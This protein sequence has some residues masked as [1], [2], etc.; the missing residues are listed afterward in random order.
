MIIQRLIQCLYGDHDRGTAYWAL[1]TDNM[2]AD[3][4]ISMMKTTEIAGMNQQVDHSRC[5]IS[6]PGTEGEFAGDDAGEPS[7]AVWERR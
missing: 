3:T 2:T 4:G 6:A 7:R 5:G 1:K